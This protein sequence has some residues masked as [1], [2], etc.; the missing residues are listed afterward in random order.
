MKARLLT[1]VLTFIVNHVNI[2]LLRCFYVVRHS[3]ILRKSTYKG[4][5]NWAVAL[6][7]IVLREQTKG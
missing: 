3:Q 1:S 4:E 6:H 7:A 2:F 5:K